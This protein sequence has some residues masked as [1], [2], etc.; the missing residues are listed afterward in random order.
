M[1]NRWPSYYDAAKD[2]PPRPTL[3]MALDAWSG[4]PGFALD[5][6]C[7]AGRDTLTLLARGWRVHAID[8]EQD[9]FAR[10]ER[11]VPAKERG[12]AYLGTTPV[13][14]HRPAQ[15]EFRQC[16][17]FLALLP[18]WDVSPSVAVAGFG[19]IPEAFSPAISSVTAIYGLGEQR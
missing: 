13:R 10:L 15:S 2:N 3:L 11:S 8:V 1:Q 4:S 14:G 19:S 6:G 18:P 7:G 16:E 9:A 17:L 5:L 12:A